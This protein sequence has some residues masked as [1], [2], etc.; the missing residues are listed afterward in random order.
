MTLH[1]KRKKKN[2]GDIYYGVFTSHKRP[3][4]S[5]SGQCY[6][7]AGGHSVGRPVGHCL[8][9][10]VPVL[11]LRVFLSPAGLVSGVVG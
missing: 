2:I 5:V 10:G 9:T 7:M 1:L 4:R 6:A 8:P 3:C 11:L